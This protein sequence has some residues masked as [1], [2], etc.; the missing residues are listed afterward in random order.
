MIKILI[1]YILISLYIVIVNNIGF[2]LE[3][4]HSSKFFVYFSIRTIL[5]FIFYFFISYIQ[6]LKFHIKLSILHYIIFKYQI[7]LIFKIISLSSLTTTIIH[8]LH[9]SSRYTKKNKK[10]YTK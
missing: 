9:L 2:L 5:F 6:I 8:Y 7:F 4:N 10:L 3:S 1:L